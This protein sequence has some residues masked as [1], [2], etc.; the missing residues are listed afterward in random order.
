MTRATRALAFFCL[1]VLPAHSDADPPRCPREMAAVAGLP[2]CIDRYEASLD[3]GD[4]GAPDGR[5]TTARAVAKKGAVPAV[6]VSHAQAAAACDNAKKRLCTRD[7]WTAACRG[8]GGRRR[9]PYGSSYEPRR[10]NDRAR[11][12]G[13]ALAPLPAG[14]LSRCRTVEGVH[15][16]SGNVWEWIAA[17]DP[18]GATASFLGGGQG[19]D[20]DDKNLSCV[21]EDPMGQ[22][23]TQQMS[24]LGF[25]CCRDLDPLN[26]R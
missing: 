5:G 25:R 20:D 10:C 6:D 7:E 13:T 12:G 9:Y 17:T 21:P 24:G 23:V 16:L 11:S 19:N 8:E 3:R 4:R 15:D 22:P 26:T 2:V 14:S 1:A 18:S